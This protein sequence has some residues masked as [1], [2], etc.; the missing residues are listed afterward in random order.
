MY[1]LFALFLRKWKKA[2]MY[3]NGMFMKWILI[4]VGFVFSSMVY[5]A[6]EKTN[7]GI[8]ILL[9]SS[10]NPV[11]LEKIT[12]LKKKLLYLTVAWNGTNSNIADWLKIIDKQ[13][14]K[15]KIIAGI[16]I[17]S[18]K[19]LNNESAKYFAHIAGKAAFV[20]AKFQLQDANKWRVIFANEKRNKN[21]M[22]TVY[23]ANALLQLQ[24]NPDLASAFLSAKSP[25][26][27]VFATKNI[28]KKSA[29]LF[30]DLVGSASKVDRAPI[31]VILLSDPNM[32][33]QMDY[34]NIMKTSLYHAENNMQWIGGDDVK[35]MNPITLSAKKLTVWQSHQAETIGLS[36][37]RIDSPMSLYEAIGMS[38]QAFR[39]LSN[40]MIRAQ[41][42][43]KAGVIFLHTPDVLID[44]S[45]TVVC[46]YDK[47]DLPRFKKNLVLNQINQ[48]NLLINT[49]SIYSVRK[50]FSSRIFLKQLKAANKIG[51]FDYSA[52]KANIYFYKRLH[53]ALLHQKNIN[54]T[55]NTNSKLALSAFQK[56]QKDLDITNIDYGKNAILL[57]NTL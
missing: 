10:V 16:E 17:D 53:R 32:Q 8:H 42:N 33:N 12:N 43:A 6:P 9:G 51:L 24:E 45:D 1:F 23:G 29:Y 2:K 49:P 35:K 7:S 56:M 30:W 13:A 41:A 15:N 52:S 22:T 36:Y 31:I 11:A 37:D 3:C 38:N 28:S 25:F 57:E 19:K 44:L 46:D 55:F 14:S 4:I 50:L 20:S 47:I 39:I 54:I 5:A 34:N 18:Y 21:L 48:L 40:L 27:Y 26:V